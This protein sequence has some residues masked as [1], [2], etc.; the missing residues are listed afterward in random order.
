MSPVTWD[1]AIG[2]GIF[3]EPDDFVSHVMQSRI[4]VRLLAIGIALRCLL[5][6]KRHW[7]SA[8]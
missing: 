5:T 1:D 7:D 8:E 6:G 4:S 2:T 3:D